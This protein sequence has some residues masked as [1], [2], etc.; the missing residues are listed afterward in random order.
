MGIGEM[1]VGE[2]VNLCRRNGCRRNGD[3]KIGLLPL[4]VPA[5]LSAVRQALGH[6]VSMQVDS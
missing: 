1:G 2:M 6:L 3:F 5:Q 4:S